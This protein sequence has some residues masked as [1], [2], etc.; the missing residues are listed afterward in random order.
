MYAYILMILV[1]IFYAGNI[2]T[3]KAMNELPPFTIAFFRLLVAFLVLLPIGFRQAWGDREKVWAFRR[4]FLIM[5]LTGVTFFNTFIYGALQFTT[6]SNVSVLESAIPA[7]TVVL[8]ALWIGER[9]RKAQW[10]GV[11]LSF[12]GALWVV[13]DGRFFQLLSIDWNVGDFIMVG[14]V[15]TW[16]VYS[17]YVKQYIHLF[18]AYGAVLNMTAISL[19]VLLPVMLV[20]WW[21]LGIP[22]LFRMEFLV[23]FL[24]LGIF[25]SFIALIFYNKAVDVLGASQ[26]AIFLNFLPV[27][28]MIGAYV[29]LGETITTAGIA[30]AILVITGVVMT[31]QIRRKNKKRKTGDSK[32]THSIS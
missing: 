29:W 16:A 28:T 11:V 3:G 27:F 2:L 26:A 4:P 7:V 9:L 18:K 15:G 10:F 22:S 20:E 17:I 24:Y 19:V 8:S 1:V 6:A 25:P 12:I 30:G 13:L 23:G 5:T 21:A 31:T 32:R 14:A